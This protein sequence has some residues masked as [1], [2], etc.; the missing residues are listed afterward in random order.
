LS[1][2]SGRSLFS[3]LLMLQKKLFPHSFLGHWSYFA[4][5]SDATD[6]RLS[7]LVLLNPFQNNWRSE[8]IAQAPSSER[9]G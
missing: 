9:E 3:Y 4:H 5:E 7:R 8:K 2:V 1:S 6:L